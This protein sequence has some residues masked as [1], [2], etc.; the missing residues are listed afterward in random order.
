MSTMKP[1]LTL[2]GWGSLYR[3]HIWDVHPHPCHTYGTRP[4]WGLLK[5]RERVI[6][7]KLFE[8]GLK[9]FHLT[10]QKEDSLSNLQKGG[11]ESN[12][13][14]HYKLL[15]DTEGIL[16]QT[17]S[18]QLWNILH[19]TLTY[20]FHFNFRLIIRWSLHTLLCKE[21]DASSCIS[22][23]LLGFSIFSS[24]EWSWRLNLWT[25]REKKRKDH[26]VLFFIF[27]SKFEEATQKPKRKRRIEGSH[28]QP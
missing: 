21:I 23:A 22:P 16:K 26:R 15:S 4:D 13:K 10:K 17:R 5:T 14:R 2:E 27:F 28:G 7:Y 18:W 8:S 1:W 24:P 19:T 6:H 9:L 3:D 12:W 11:N 20:K 25:E